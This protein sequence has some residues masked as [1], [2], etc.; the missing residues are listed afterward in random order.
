MATPRSKQAELKALNAEIAVR[1]KYKRDQ[2]AQIAE[3][4]ESGNTQ[5]M[6][7]HHDIVTAKQE[8]RSIKTDIR[9]AAQ[10]KVLLTEDL[11]QLQKELT[12]LDPEPTPFIGVVP[13]FG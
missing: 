11:T 8:L 2:E 7:L 1:A 5:L 10:D 12:E 6:G 13:A 4:V 3:L 9:T